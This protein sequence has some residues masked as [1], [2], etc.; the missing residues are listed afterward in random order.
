MAR[1]PRPGGGSRSSSAG[2]LICSCES[3]CP[4]VRAN[5]AQFK[6]SESHPYRILTLQSLPSSL[7]T[8]SGIRMAD[9][10]SFISLWSARA[11]RPGQHDALDAQSRPLV[12]Q[13][14]SYCVELR[15][16]GAHVVY[17]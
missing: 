6:A 17:E 10:S 5:R 13:A 15:P 11:T 8:G 3:S 14:G 7:G 1:I 2:R 4:G 9:R 12:R 16:R